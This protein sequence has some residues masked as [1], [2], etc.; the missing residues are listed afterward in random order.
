MKLTVATCQFPIAGD[1]RA[2]LGCIARQ[3]RA[4]KR[5][6]AHLVHFPECALSGYAGIEF[7]SFRG[8]DWALLEECTR[9]VCALAR[10]LRVHVVLGSSHRLTG[11]N[12]PRNCLY[13][14]DARGRI[15]DRYDKMFCTGNARNTSGDLKH[16]TSGDHFVCFTV[17]GVRCGLLICHD[18]RYPELCREYKKRGVQL[19]LHSYHN[20][21]ISRTRARQLG[22]NVW[23]SLVPATMQAYAAVNYFW[24]SANNTSRPIS[25]W[26]SFYVL[27]DGTIGKTMKEHATGMLVFTVNPAQKFFDA[28]EDWRERALRGV[29]HS[30]RSVKDA[31][32]R[33]R[34]GL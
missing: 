19:M 6:G 2:N 20:G 26:P 16:Y 27:P 3:M 8:Y 10:K 22:K 13:V 23:G 32:S 15:V 34:R 21:N 29:F 31:R 1:I 11:R 14:I 25:Q 17:R 12:K 9:S 24:I 28:S 7:A 4:A 33:N 30:G 5:G 18:F